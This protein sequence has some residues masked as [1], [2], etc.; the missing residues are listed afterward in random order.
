MVAEEI[1]NQLREVDEG[2]DDADRHVG[3]HAGF[4]ER[5]RLGVDFHSHRQAIDEQRAVGADAEHTIEN[6]V[7]PRGHERFRAG[8]I[9]AEGE[10]SGVT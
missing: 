8:R 2:L 10:N 7:G 9:Q 3:S 5:A 6:F 4:C 1:Q